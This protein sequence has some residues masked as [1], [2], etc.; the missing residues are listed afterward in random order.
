LPAGAVPGK[1]ILAAHSAGG[2]P[3]SAIL[4]TENNLI[5]NIDECWCFDCFYHY[6]WEKVLEKNT[7]IPFYHYWAYTNN[8]KMSAPGLRGETLAKTYRNLKNIQPA[9]GIHHREVIEYAWKNE[10]NKRSWFTPIGSGNNGV[11][12]EIEYF[13]EEFETSSFEKNIKAYEFI[14]FTYIRLGYTENAVVNLIF[15]ILHPELGGRKLQ[16]SDPKSLKQEWIDVKSKLVTPIFKKY[17]DVPPLA[18]STDKVPAGFTEGRYKTWT[19]LDRKSAERI[20]EA[21]KRLNK[22]GKLN[23]MGITDADIDTFQRIANAETGGHLQNFYSYDM[24]IISMGFRQFTFIHKNI[25]DWINKA[26]LAFKKYGIETDTSLPPYKIKRNTTKNGEVKEIIYE[27][28]RIKGVDDPEIL[29]WN[30]WAQRFYYA[31]LDDDIVIAEFQLGKEFFAKELGRLQ[32]YLKDHHGLFEMFMSYYNQSPHL[33]AMFHELNNAAPS[34]VPTV[35]L[36]TLNKA[37][38]GQ[39]ADQF[40]EIF[41]QTVKENWPDP[42]QAERIFDH[43]K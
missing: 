39:S 18:Y 37:S 35:V 22:T 32:T 8:G 36:K 24:A 23:S 43:T 34:R 9:T 26:P 19:G 42:E 30:G 4:R 25:Y 21:A 14:A 11:A 20:D 13:T 16:D 15:K 7:G 5:A 31:G 28:P 2:Y 3:M 29:R 38:Q 6:Q 41:R 12:K 33:R 10:I 17:M 1:I 40:I 27:V